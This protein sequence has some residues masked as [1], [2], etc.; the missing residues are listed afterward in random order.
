MLNKYILRRHPEIILISNISHF[1]NP[2]HP[3]SSHLKLHLDPNLC[4][5]LGKKAKKGYI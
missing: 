5:N 2:V 4:S 3:V 1:G